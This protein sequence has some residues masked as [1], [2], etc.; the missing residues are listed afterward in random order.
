M[1]GGKSMRKKRKK[2]HYKTKFFLVLVL[3][4]YLSS[5]HSNEIGFDAE[6][7]TIYTI[8][9]YPI[10]RLSI[11]MINADKY[12]IISK[13]NKKSGTTWIRLDSIGEDYEIGIDK[14]NQFLKSSEN[15]KIPMIPSEIYEIEH[16]SIGGAT[17]CVIRVMTDK[18]GRIKKIERQ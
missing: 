7:H 1:I 13:M 8:D 3:I 4:Q 5:C 11:Y 18:K 15:K 6:T 12:F 2:M 9:N 14:R 16:Y 17:P 10:N